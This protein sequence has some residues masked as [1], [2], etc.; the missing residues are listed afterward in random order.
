MR[1][2]RGW[3]LIDFEGE[4]ATALAGRAG[5]DS[6]L[7]DVAGMLRSF[8]YAAQ[9][10]TTHPNAHDQ[11]GFRAVEWAAHNGRAFLDGYAETT[12]TDPRDQLPLLRAYQMDK[13]VYESLYESRNRPSWLHIPLGSIK[14]QLADPAVEVHR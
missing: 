14:R 12:G 4:P 7:R 3:K 13:A 6:A 11:A 2:V 1:T 5:L 10:M 9:S 8:D